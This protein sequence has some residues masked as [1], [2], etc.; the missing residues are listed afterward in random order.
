MKPILKE[1][2]ILLASLGIALLYTIGIS[3][4]WWGLWN[5]LAVE[6][7][8]LK[9]LTWPQAFGL[10]ALLQIAFKGAYWPSLK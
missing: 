1:I 4:V 10:L 5:W 2:G 3:L 9:P 7:F 8:G 6:L